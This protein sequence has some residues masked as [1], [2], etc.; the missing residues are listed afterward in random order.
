MINATTTCAVDNTSS[1]TICLTENGVYT[2]N[3]FS[4]GDILIILLLMMILLVGLFAQFKAV[5]FGYKIE[6]PQKNKY[7]KDI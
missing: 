3:G 5:L 4:Y 2:L 7:T 6:N 1:S